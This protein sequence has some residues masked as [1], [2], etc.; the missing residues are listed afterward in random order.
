MPYF[1]WT[2]VVFVLPA[3]LI[4][5]IASASVKATFNKYSRHASLRGMTGAEAVR[6]VLGAHGLGYIVVERVSGQLTDH[7]DP[8]NQILR[9]SDS[10]FSSTS[11][12]AIG[13]AAHEAGHAIQ[14]AENYGPAKLRSAIVPMTNLGSKLSMP[15]I[16]AGIILSYFAMDLIVIAYVGIICFGACVLF[17]LV[18]LPTEFDASRRAIKV[19][20]STGILDQSEIKDVKKVLTAAAMTYVAAL[21]STVLQMLRLIVIVGQSSGRRRD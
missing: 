1:D 16:I 19:L 7:F 11:T 2:Y 4:T 5:L 13:V 18:T 3:L 6:R 10:T 21:A 14:H 15:L 12:A 20:S 9:L 8:K 17:Q